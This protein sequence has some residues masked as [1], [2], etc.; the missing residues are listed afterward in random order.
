[1]A[2]ETA[3]IVPVAGLPVPGVAAQASPV[4]VTEVV[5][6]PTMVMKVVAAE[7]VTVSMKIVRMAAEKSMAETGAEAVKA[8]EAFGHRVNLRQNDGEKERGN[9]RNGFSQQHC[10]VDQ[11]IEVSVPKVHGALSALAEINSTGLPIKQSG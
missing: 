9:N 3:R 7:M 2:A 4:P 8:A 10:L 1:V 5:A 6:G 11:A